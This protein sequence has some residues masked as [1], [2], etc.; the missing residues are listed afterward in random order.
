[1]K[2]EEALAALE[3][4]LEKTRC[5]IVLVDDEAM[6]DPEIEGSNFAPW[7][8]DGL[9]RAIQMEADRLRAELED[10]EDTP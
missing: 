1:M 9:A 10:P 6:N 5:L 2:D 4:Q 8:L 7:E 3:Q